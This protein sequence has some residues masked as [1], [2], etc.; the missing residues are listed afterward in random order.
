[1][2]DAGNNIVAAISSMATDFTETLR[3]RPIEGLARGSLAYMTGGLSE[4]ANSVVDKNIR[5]PQRT[6]EGL[7]AKAS[8][9]RQAMLAE[10]ERFKDAEKKNR[11]AQSAI[12]QRVGTQTPK[13][14]STILTS[15]LGTT[16]Q[17]RTIL[18]G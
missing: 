7:A 8:G 5:E 16:G 14:R 12:N 13:T 18:G 4:V 10:E 6:A 1:M 15:P 2:G 17:G 9:E 3:K 11:A